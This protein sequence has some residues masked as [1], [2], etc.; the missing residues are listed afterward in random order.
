MLNAAPA[1]QKSIVFTDDKAPVEWITNAMVLNFIFSD[2][3]DNM[4]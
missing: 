4:Q 2:E 3:V 1:P